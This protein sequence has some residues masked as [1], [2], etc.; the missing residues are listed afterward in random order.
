MMLITSFLACTKT[1]Y[2]G[3]LIENPNNFST[4]YSSV[5]IPYSIDNFPTSFVLVDQNGTEIPYQLDDLN[6]DG[7]PEVLFFQIS[8]DANSSSTISV[9]ETENK[10]EYAFNTD[11]TI[12]VRDIKDPENMQVSRDF[13]SVQQY[14]ETF[15]FKQD[16]GLIFLEGPGW[17][18][19]LIGYR[20]Y[21]DDRNRIDIF[22]KSTSKLAL[23]DIS[24]TYHERREWGADILKVGASLG[25]G[26]PALFADGKFFTIENTGTKSLKILSDGPL[27]SILQV[28]YDDWEINNQK[29][30]VILQ[31][32]IHANHRYTELRLDT[33]LED[34]EFATGLVMH[35]AIQEIVTQS[36]DTYSY[37]YTWGKQTD[38][39]ETLGMGIIIPQELNPKYQ[40]EL[41]ET[42]VFSMANDKSDITYRFLGAWELE[43]E[44]VRINTETDFETYIN[45]VAKQWQ[46]PLKVTKK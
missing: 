17:E 37:G 32:E 1:N 35:P 26:T 4:E 11:I 31:L 3:F 40:G 9:Q 29:T 14:T 25:I 7:N 30:D 33:D 27:R 44:N 15:D 18:S 13:Q 36:R 20:L 24:E 6:Q 41:Q 12:K 34:V 28:S 21:F 19:N 39:D 8:L 16:N 45:Q 42:Y 43:P 38:L 5:T 23:N 10:P 2:S 46:S 22:G